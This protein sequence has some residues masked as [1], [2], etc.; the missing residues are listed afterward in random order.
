CASCPGKHEVE[1]D[2]VGPV[3]VECLQRIGAGRAEGHLEALLAQHVRKGVADRLLV[4]DNEHKC[5]V[6]ALADF[7][8]AKARQSPGCGA[9]TT[10]MGLIPAIGWFI[11]SFSHRLPLYSANEWTLVTAG[12]MMAGR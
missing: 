8:G 9:S 3:E 6:T 10:P 11:C 2:Q 12:V 7:C 5:H 1:Q 4:L